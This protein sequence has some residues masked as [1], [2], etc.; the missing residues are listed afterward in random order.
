MYDLSLCGLVPR[1]IG[2]RK[3]EMWLQHIAGR[4]C[5][6]LFAFNAI[7]AGLFLLGNA[8]EFLES[9]QLLLLRMLKTGSIV[10]LCTLVYFIVI[11]IVEGIRLGRFRFG[12]FFLALGG[13]AIVS[14][15]FFLSNF[16]SSWT[17]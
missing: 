7:A 16:I 3:R 9:T 1:M 10:F 11:L 15:V 8:Q 2:M 12:L 5:I 6:F 13:G 14:L 4:L 17:G